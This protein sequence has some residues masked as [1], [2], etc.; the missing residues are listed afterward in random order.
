VPSPVG[1]A[2]WCG[3]CAS[4]ACVM[5][6][7]GS[8]CG[9]GWY[10]GEPPFPVQEQQVTTAQSSCPG[11]SLPPC[12]DESCPGPSPSCVTTSRQSRSR[13]A[14]CARRSLCTAAFWHTKCPHPANPRGI[15]PAH[16]RGAGHGTGG[17]RGW[18]CRNLF[19]TVSGHENPPGNPVHGWDMVALSGN[20]GASLRVLDLSG[21]LTLRSVDVVRSCTQLRCLWM[22][23]CFNV[24]DLSPLAA[25]SET[26]EELWM[27]R[28]L[29]VVSLAP[30]KACTRLRKLDL[31][32]C[33][34]VLLNQAECLR[35]ACDPLTVKFEGPVHELQ[36]N[37]PPGMQQAAATELWMLT[38]NGGP[39][40]Q[41]AIA[42]GACS[43]LVRL[44]APAS[45]E[46]LQVALFHLAYTVAGN[47]AVVSAG[48]IPALE[49]LLES[50]SP[51]ARA[52]VAAALRTLSH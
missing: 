13:G 34:P 12:D 14:A 26:L 4:H 44:L 5:P 36:P 42:A 41:A 7:P 6:P 23:G 50:G 48:A 46:A 8:W 3:G 18:L 27:G 19:D 49:M 47:M 15:Q 16:A 31:R 43:P 9:G 39:Q 2:S 10:P 32:G 51:G 30:L 33:S 24:T 45:S 17:G 52:A 22:P 37:M 40:I 11:P 35:L 1:G 28:A 20:V 25:C 29:S 21:C 38:D